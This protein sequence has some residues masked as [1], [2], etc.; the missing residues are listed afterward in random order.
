[1]YRMYMKIGAPM[2]AVMTPAGRDPGIFLTAI[3]AR[4][5][6]NAPRI[7]DVGIRTLLS[8][9]T[10]NLA[11]CGPIR[12]TKPIVPVKHTQIIF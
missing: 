5:I 1:M 6:I 4:R 9:P 3:S 2:R 11:I 8:L 7:A 10:N 12:P